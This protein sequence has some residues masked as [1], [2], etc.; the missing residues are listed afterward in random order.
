[1]DPEVIITNLKKRYTGVSGTIN[2]LLPAQAK[3]LKIG[4]VG[5]D[6]PGAQRAKQ[7]NPENFSYLTLWKRSGYRDSIYQMAAT[8]SGM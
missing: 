2:A 8:A 6:L 3:T 7:E 1:M 4:F 5:T